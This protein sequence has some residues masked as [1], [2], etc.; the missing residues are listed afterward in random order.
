[1]VVQNPYAMGFESI[2]L[3]KSLVAKDDAAVKEMFPKWGEAGGDIFDTGLKVVVPNADSPLKKDQFPAN[4]EFLPLDEFK[5]WL[6]K[7]NLSGS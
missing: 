1:M 2:R 6:A 3:L 7:Y 5:A 4:V